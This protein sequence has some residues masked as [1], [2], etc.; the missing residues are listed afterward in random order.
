MLT[1]FMDGAKLLYISQNWK[2]VRRQTV[3]T[4]AQISKVNWTTTWSQILHRYCY[5]L[6]YFPSDYIYKYLQFALEKVVKIVTVF[7]WKLAVWYY[8][9][10]RVGLVKP[11]L[12]YLY[13]QGGRKQ[14]CVHFFYPLFKRFPQVYLFKNL[15]VLF[16][17]KVPQLHIHSKL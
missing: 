7:C 13:Y 8:M 16:L 3:P 6:S 2:S 1:Q 15:C 17:D 4:S 5:C 11:I 9:S 12:I 10:T 14:F